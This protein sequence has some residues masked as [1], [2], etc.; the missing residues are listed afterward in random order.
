MAHEDAGHYAAKH[1]GTQINETIASAIKGKISADKT[2]SCAEA[3]SIAAK[4]NVS[5]AEVGVTIDQ[6]EVRINKCQL[7]LFG[8][9]EKK[10]IPALS[11]AADAEAVKAIESSLANGRL[12]CAAAW[13]IAK[14]FNMPKSKVSAICESMN[15]KISACQLG[16][17]K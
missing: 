16:A 17:F 2:I 12:S 9:P 10:N 6:L 13:E 3:H 4:L 11:G 14:K 5:P 8:Y 15:L 1:S 7:G